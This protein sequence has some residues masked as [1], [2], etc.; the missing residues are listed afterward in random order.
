MSE[1]LNLKQQVAE[2]RKR[3]L[4]CVKNLTAE[5]GTFKPEENVWSAAEITEHLYIAELGGIVGMWKALE[6][7]KIGDPPWK[8]EHFNRGLTIEQ[9]I[10]K[11]WQ[12]KENVPDGA[13]PRMLGPLKIWMCALESCESLLNVLAENLEGKE[14]ENIIYPHPISGP[15]DVRQR[16]EFLRFH[17]DRHRAQV[18]RLKQDPAFPNKN[19]ESEK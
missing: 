5:Q 19:K 15:L 11:T 16:F 9:V 13:G 6:G 18:E 4:N 2:A 7:D 8:D 10:E 1:L 3:Y 14:L 12:S 17:M